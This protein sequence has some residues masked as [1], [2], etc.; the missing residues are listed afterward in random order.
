VNVPVPEP[1]T[2][3][4]EEDLVV[5]AAHQRVVDEELAGRQ[6]RHADEDVISGGKLGLMLLRNLKGL[7]AG[8]RQIR[9]GHSA[10]IARLEQASGRLFSDLDALL[11]DL[12]RHFAEKFGGW[13]PL[14][15]KNR[16]LHGIVPLPGGGGSRILGV[17]LP[18]PAGAPVTTAT[19]PAGVAAGAGV[20][21]GVLDTQVYAHDV[22]AGHLSDD[23]VLRPAPASPAAYWRGHGLFVASRILARA[24]SAT[25]DLRPL[26]DDTGHAT[27]WD[28]AMAMVGFLDAQPA[29][30]VAVLNLSLGGRTADG[31]PPLVLSR[32]V[33]QLS[34][35]VLIV[36]AAGNH[37]DSDHPT[38]QIW[39]AA[40]PDVI[41]VGA[42]REPHSTFSPELP[43]IT[44]TARA[45]QVVGAYLS[46]TVTDRDGQEVPGT[47]A[48]H[49]SWSGTSFAA[50]TVSGAIAARMAPGGTAREALATLLATG[51]DGVKPYRLPD[52]T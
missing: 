18:A 38:A 45:V 6:I 40:H 44:C 39:P 27:A 36:A 17:S 3:F 50:A 31:Q 47:F 22:L 23:H 35:D 32:A 46:G 48:G 34:P 16:H 29:G 52:T 51:D 19:A 7:D 2:G 10:E 25:L 11:W 26:L 24:P 9:A 43:W 1:T 33:D 12:R 5:A 15:G 28:T 41:A 37:G 14:M 20:R 21:I 42:T 4:V 30:R 49:A 8:A 13:V